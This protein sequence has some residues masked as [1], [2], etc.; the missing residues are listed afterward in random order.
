M[1][2]RL[3]ERKDLKMALDI[4]GLTY[5]MP[6][7]GFLFIFVIIFALLT[8][9]KILGDSKFVSILISFIIAI[10]F[11]T[12]SSV[13][14]YVETV[15]PWFAVL[16]VVLF[17]ILIIIGLSQQKIDSIMKPGFVWVFII[18]LIIVFLVSAIKV[19]S[20]SLNPVFYDVKYYITTESKVAGGIILLV[21]AAIA[22]WVLTKK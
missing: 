21:I 14:E 16:V 15:T 3:L 8:K 7:F 10:I 2:L 22:T 12:M 17:F 19:F 9:T 13:R 18:L 6:I 20:S 5:F 4:S 11:A 1:Q